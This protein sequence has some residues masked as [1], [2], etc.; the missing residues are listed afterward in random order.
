[1]ISEVLVGRDTSNYIFL[2]GLFFRLEILQRAW[3]F[4]LGTHILKCLGALNAEKIH[5]PQ[6]GSNSRNSDL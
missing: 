2:L 6:A 5:C 3:K 1:M 4:R